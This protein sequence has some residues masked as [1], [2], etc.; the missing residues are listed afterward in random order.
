MGDK[1]PP[2]IFNEEIIYDNAPTV[3]TPSATVITLIEEPF[4]PLIKMISPVF[5][6]FFKLEKYPDA[7][8]VANVAF[9]L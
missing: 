7:V 6:R 5:I 1:H 3:T 4:E 2:T 8:I 9:S